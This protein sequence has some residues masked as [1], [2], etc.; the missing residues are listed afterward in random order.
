MLSFYRNW[1]NAS[2]NL[3]NVNPSKKDFKARNNDSWPEGIL[4]N[5]KSNS[6]GNEMRFYVKKSIREVIALI[7]RLRN[8]HDQY[9]IPTKHDYGDAFSKWYW[10]WP[11][12]NDL[13]GTFRAVR[14]DWKSF[15]GAQPRAI[16]RLEAHKVKRWIRCLLYLLLQREW[17]RGAYCFRMQSLFPCWL[18]ELMA[19]QGKNMSFV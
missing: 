2:K 7:F 16:W 13:L 4:L 3:P 9:G 12:S 14:K 10:H 17:W 19:F 8:S 18:P 1:K 15:K 11:W 6:W 5:R